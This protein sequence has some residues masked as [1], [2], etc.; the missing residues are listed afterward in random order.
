MRAAVIERVGLQQLPVGAQDITWDIAGAE[1]E[2]DL[3]SAEAMTLRG[4]V[5]R[6]SARPV[7][8]GL[9][10]AMRLAYAAF[11]LGWW[12]MA[13]ESA[14]GEDRVRAAGQAERYLGSA[15]QICHG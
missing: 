12:R 5:A 4:S 2:F 14:E 15:R 13:A 3:S 8:E 6:I 1:A 11:Q 9:L 7:D 10:R